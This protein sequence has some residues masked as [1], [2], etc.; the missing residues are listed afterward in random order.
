MF[1]A[2]GP[3][4]AARPFQLDNDQV[5]DY[6]IEAERSGERLPLVAQRNWH[7]PREWNRTC[8]ELECERVLVDAL[9]KP[10]AE[11]AMDLD[12]CTDHRVGKLVDYD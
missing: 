12:G 1:G 8:F 6:E 3:P 11:L 4:K 9:V 10:G 7:L 5:S 2:G